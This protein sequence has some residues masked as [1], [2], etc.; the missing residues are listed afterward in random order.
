MQVARYWRL[1]SQLYRM[2]NM[3]QTVTSTPTTEIQTPAT[4][5]TK[6]ETLAKSDTKVA[7]AAV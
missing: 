7:A 3:R 5:V 1:K 2:E 6:Q 4:Q